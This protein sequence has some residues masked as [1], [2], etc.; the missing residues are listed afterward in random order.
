M[1][2]GLTGTAE[3]AGEML[4][5]LVDAAE[6]FV[7]EM[8]PTHED[9][10]EGGAEGAEDGDADAMAARKKKLE[11]LRKKMRSSAKANRASVIEES[12]KAKMTARE[13]ARLER[14]RKLAE[15]L[16]QKADA[17]ERGEDMERQKNWE[18]TIEENDEW[19]KKLAKKARR[20]DFSFNDDADAA[21]RKY[22]KDLDHLK[23]DLESYNRQ[24]EIA[25][26]LAAGTL[27]KQ[28]QASG[29]SAVT[30]F[31]PSSGVMTGPTSLQQQLAA[32]NLY[33]D[34]NS[35]LYADNKPSEDAIDRVISK[36]NKDVDKKSKFSR[37]R[38][39]EDEGD[40]TYINERNRVFNKKIARYY[41]KYTAEIRASFERGTAL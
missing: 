2:S 39:N 19:E 12:A 3:K 28:G 23:P 9:E 31:D 16:R 15:T 26:G 37:K 21:R 22:K 18:Y 36:I 30:A 35:L 11:E 6:D 5:K 29:S 4:N 32:E 1:S 40:I 34:A 27:T 38:H 10:Q 17:E 25:L 20:A 24:K 41:D 8:N 33:R 7:D 13:A 14:Q